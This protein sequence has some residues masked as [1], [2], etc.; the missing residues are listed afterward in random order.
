MA[1][2]GRTLQPPSFLVRMAFI[3]ERRLLLSGGEM[4]LK[5]FEE[6]KLPITKFGQPEQHVAERGA[7]IFKAEQAGHE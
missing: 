4:L 3:G 6:S 1:S 2:C 5:G 7:A